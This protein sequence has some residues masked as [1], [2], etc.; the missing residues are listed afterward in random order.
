MVG[1]GKMIKP[2]FT[3]YTKYL[4]N[5]KEKTLGHLSGKRTIKK[6]RGAIPKFYK[7]FEHLKTIKA[8]GKVLCLGAR[9][10][11]EVEAFIQLGY[12]SIGIDLIEWKPYVIAMDMMDMKF[13]YKFD[14]IYTNSI[15]HCFDLFKFIQQIKNNLN[16]NGIAVIDFVHN[17]RKIIGTHEAVNIET[18][19]DLT[20]AFYDNGFKL[21]GEYH[22]LQKRYTK[23]RAIGRA[24]ED[25]F[26][27][28]LK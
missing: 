10:G 27:F 2:V 11:M 20:G 24:I 5:Q 12:E 6:D 18:C 13:D 9:S 14:I 1:V 16:L 21:I 7:R 26:I 23:G 8:G 15:D 17:K 25:Q 19:E 28:G 3:D 4:E 22:T